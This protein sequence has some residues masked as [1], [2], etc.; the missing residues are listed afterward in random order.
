MVQLCDYE[1]N[2]ISYMT[3]IPYNKISDDQFQRAMLTDEVIKKSSILG[4]MLVTKSD[5]Q[6]LG[7]VQGR[8]VRH[9]AYLI[10]VLHPNDFKAVT[11]RHHS[12]TD[13]LKAVLQK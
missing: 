5:S 1:P 8:L 9:S 4:R 10:F 2:D 12:C 3:H 11:Q 13:L 7:G 6:L